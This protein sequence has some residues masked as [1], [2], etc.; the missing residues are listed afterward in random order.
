MR[1]LGIDQATRVTGYGLIDADGPRLTYVECGVL[2]APASWGR[3]R[4]LQE[5]HGGLVEVLREH[6]REGLVAVLEGGVDRYASAALAGGE[7]RGVAMAALFA[8]GVT[9]ERV[10]EVAPAAM[11][12]AVTGA[13]GASKE[14]VARMVRLALGLRAPP[15]LDATDALGLAIAWARGVTP[16]NS[17]RRPRVVGS[18]RDARPDR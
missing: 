14:L 10:H 17:R 7:A 2:E 18:A 1:I 5:I 4:R 3:Q 13:G 15:P 16:T 8:A 6:L 11:K 12:A 9:W